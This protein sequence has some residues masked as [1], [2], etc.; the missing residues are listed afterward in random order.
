MS[1]SESVKLFLQL[2]GIFFG[3][4]GRQHGVGCDLR[5][6]GVLRGAVGLPD[7]A[8]GRRCRVCSWVAECWR[9]T[10]R[11]RR[12]DRANLR[13]SD[14]GR[15][16]GGSVRR[17]G[18]DDPATGW[19]LLTHVENSAAQRQ[20]EAERRAGGGRAVGRGRPS[21]GQGEAARQQGEAERR[22]GRGRAAAGGGR[23]AADGGRPAAGGGRPA[24]GR[25][26]DRGVGGV[27]ARA[28]RRQPVTTS[29]PSGHH[30]LTTA[31]MRLSPTA[32]TL[33]RMVPVLRPR[34]V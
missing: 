2:S 19:D 5:C 9:A 33:S 16:R 28:R 27:A 29:G 20:G 7:A 22:A 34:V 14:H 21:G 8:R 6:R 17:F 1:A 25:S 31:V 26:A 15:R 18:S 3:I 4:V 11:R 10:R 12:G 13:Q 30:S 24:A 32:L 23:P